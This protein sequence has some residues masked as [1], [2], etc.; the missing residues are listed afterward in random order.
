MHLFKLTSYSAVLSNLQ[1]FT[2]GVDKFCLRCIIKLLEKSVEKT[3]N[4]EKK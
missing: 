3:L 4:E 2:N 1:K